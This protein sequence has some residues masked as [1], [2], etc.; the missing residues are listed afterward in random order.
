[1]TLFSSYP[2][3]SEAYYVLSIDFDQRKTL[4]VIIIGR[5]VNH[6][7]SSNLHHL[8]LVIL[9]VMPIFRPPLPII[10]YLPISTTSTIRWA[11][12]DDNVIIIKYA[13]FIM[14]S[15]D[16]FV[17]VSQSAQLDY[18]FPMAPCNT[19]K[20]NHESKMEEPQQKDRISKAIYSPNKPIQEWSL[21]CLYND[22]S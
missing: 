20:R 22:K 21:S 10:L 19:M 8:Y 18:E 14:L 3:W 13:S 2:P 9:I 6:F 5:L 11:E 4:Y 17:L 15:V 12:S 16:K 7:Y 1:M